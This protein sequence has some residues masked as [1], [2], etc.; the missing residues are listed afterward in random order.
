MT[1]Q[2]KERQAERKVKDSYWAS[3]AEKSLFD[4]YHSWIG[5]T[6]TNPMSAET[7]VV[8]NAGKMMELSL[9]ENLQ[10]M[11]LLKRF[12]GDEQLHFRIE[13]QGIPISGYTDGIF[14]NGDPI[15]IKSF[16]GDYQ[17]KELKAGKPRTSYLK[18]LAIYLDALGRTFGTLCYLDRGTGEIYE[19]GLLRDSVNTLE[20]RCGSIEFD[21]NDTYKRWAKLYTENIVPKIEPDA[22]EN[23]LYKMPIDQI[24]WSRLSNT[25]ISKARNNQKII[26]SDKANG[27]KINYS[28]YMDLIL[29]RQGT[30]RGYTDEELKQIKSATTGYSSKTKSFNF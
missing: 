28:P 1:W 7:L 10:K 6:P 23:G 25:D 9:I 12:E 27:W 17:S 13:R 14:E 15:E 30:Q 4:L 21:L 24:D 5:T 3:E 11:G 16:Y 29:Q 8:F 2:D 18:Q 20:F 26:P 22:N 19:F